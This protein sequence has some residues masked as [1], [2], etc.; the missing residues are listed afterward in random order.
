MFRKLATPFLIIILLA[1]GGLYFFAARP[2][3]DDVC[4][5]QGIIVTAVFLMITAVLLLYFLAQKFTQPIQRLADA[6]QRLRDGKTAKHII[7]NNWGEIGQLVTIFNAMSEQIQQRF[8]TLAYDQQQLELVL[9]QM[10][11]GILFA[12][13]DGKVTLVNAA[14]ARLL[15]TTEATAINHSVAE[16][17]R[18]HELIAMWRRCRESS[19]KQTGA[20]EVGAEHVLQAVVTPFQNNDSGG[21][22]FVLQDLTQIHHL[23]TIRRDFISN[24]SHELRTPLASL[25]AVVE[26]LQDGALDDPPAANRFLHRADREID[27]LTQMVEELLELSRIESGR[28]PIKSEETAVS[29]L[30]LIPLDRLQAQA[31][32]NEVELILDYSAGLPPVWADAARAQQVVTNLLHNA[33][34]FTPSGGKITLSA[35]FIKNENEVVI[36]VKDNGVGIPAA[37]LPR[38]FERFYK[39]DRARTREQR[40]TGLGLAIARHI[41]EAHNGRIWVKSK[42][43]RGSA[44]SFTLPV[45]Q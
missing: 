24:I 17:V 16:V 18:H 37:D 38:I 5:E 26:T 9:G 8:H 28:M 21:C 31:A 29:D 10:T 3:C 11:D 32:R 25:R 12:N 44:F 45:S 14:A 43:N 23:Q 36:S 13:E 35:R 22:L 19:R 33:V 39:S 6:A 20:V 4:V 41:V 42:E 27:T 1:M 15:D 7:A 34:K 30:L 40:G 2:G